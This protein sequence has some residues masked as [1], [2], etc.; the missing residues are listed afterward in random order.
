M[1]SVKVL[2][3]FSEILSLLKIALQPVIVMM[4][5]IRY[6]GL[7]SIYCNLGYYKPNKTYAVNHFLIEGSK[8]PPQ[9]TKRT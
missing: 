9:N 4:Y 1:V 3:Y 7:F 8:F 2:N 5:S 6:I